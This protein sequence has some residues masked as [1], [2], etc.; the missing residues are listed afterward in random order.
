MSFSS[1]HS[2]AF[3]KWLISKLPVSPDLDEFVSN[4]GEVHWNEFLATKEFTRVPNHT[5]PTEPASECVENMQ[6]IINK[7]TGAGGARTNENGL[8][9][10]ELTDLKDRYNSCNLNKE[11]NVEEVTFEGYDRTFVKA[12]KSACHKYMKKI[13]AN[14]PELKP[15]SGCKEPDEAYIDPDKKIAFI[16]EKKFQRTGGSVDEKIQTGH[17]KQIHYKQL[18]PEFKI[19]YIYCLSNWFKETEYKSVLDYL[20]KNEITIFWGNSET[21][22]DDIIKFMH[23]SL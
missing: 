4:I 3:T 13:G 6:P 23:N 8:P 7:G 20:I 17:F 1:S 14:N 5:I 22:K 21:Y 18:F 9:Y 12:N 15:A 16:I 19:Y 11:H 2:I 10:E